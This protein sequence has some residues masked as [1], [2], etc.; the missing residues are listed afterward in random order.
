[1]ARLDADQA[2]RLIRHLTGGG[3]AI[4]SSMAA[5]RGSGRRSSNIGSAPGAFFAP[6]GVTVGADGAIYVNNSVFSSIGQII[7]VVP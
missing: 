7:R 2:R 3:N 6:G 5:N 4:R 1:M